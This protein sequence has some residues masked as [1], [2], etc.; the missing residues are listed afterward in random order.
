MFFILHTIYN[1]KKHGYGLLFDYL[2]WFSNYNKKDKCPNVDY[3][4]WFLFWIS[5]I[6][7]K[8]HE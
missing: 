1:G 4:K 8:K 3:K 5:S 7:G 6:M 2:A